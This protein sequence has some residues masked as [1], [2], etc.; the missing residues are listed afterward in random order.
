MKTAIYGW[1]LDVKPETAHH[2]PFDSAGSMP[3]GPPSPLGLC[4]LKGPHL[5]PSSLILATPCPGMSQAADPRESAA[6]NLPTSSRHGTGPPAAPAFRHWPPVAVIAASAWAARTRMP[7]ERGIPGSAA[8]G[9]LCSAVFTATPPPWRA[10]SCRTPALSHRC[11]PTA[12]RAHV[13][14]VRG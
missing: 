9:R 6:S 4:D 5:C 10:P 1:S 13:L 8:P 7:I 3:V 11:R 12:R 2:I 14:R